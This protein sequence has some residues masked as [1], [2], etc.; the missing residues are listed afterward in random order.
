MDQPGDLAGLP[1]V[2]GAAVGSFAAITAAFRS[3]MQAQKT[4]TTQITIITEDRNRWQI[5]AEKAEQINEE[6]RD[7]L[8]QIIID[9]SE[10][11]AQNAMMIEQI[12]NLRE[13]NERYQHQ[14]LNMT[15]GVN[16]RTLNQG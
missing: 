5:R 14:I 2:V 13:D 1:A 7:K 15:R 3:W 16:V 9:Q 12:K 10:M 8:N 4:D 11:K 6:Y